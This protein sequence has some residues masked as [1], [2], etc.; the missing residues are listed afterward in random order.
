[1]RKTKSAYGLR[2]LDTKEGHR[3]QSQEKHLVR[4]Y[5]KDFIGVNKSS[6]IFIIIL[7]SFRI[8]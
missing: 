5:S 7:D 8:K 3:N 4:T 2:L 6:V 1:M